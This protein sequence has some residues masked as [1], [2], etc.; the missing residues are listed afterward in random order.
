MISFGSLDDRLKGYTEG[1]ALL[2]SAGPVSDRFI[3]SL[4]ARDL[5]NG[6]VGSGKTTACI[7]RALLAAVRTPPMIG[8]NECPESTERVTV[9]GKWIF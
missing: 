6:P 9:L 1:A 7:K 2:Q 8:K 4:G 5:L 3:Q